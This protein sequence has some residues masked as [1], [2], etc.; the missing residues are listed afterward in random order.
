MSYELLFRPDALDE[1]HGLDATIRAQ[2]K[3]KHF[4]FLV[5]PRIVP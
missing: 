1:W 3:K 4:A 5:F 2:F